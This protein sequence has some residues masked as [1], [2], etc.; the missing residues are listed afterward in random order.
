LKNETNTN[1]LEEML[2]RVQHDREKCVIPNLFWNL[3]LGD[4][5]KA[6]VFVL[7]ALSAKKYFEQPGATI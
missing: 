1:A 2:K 3:E 5:K 7:G 4:G 6:I